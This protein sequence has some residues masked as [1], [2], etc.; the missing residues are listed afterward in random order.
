MIRT[1]PN[2]GEK[3]TSARTHDK[4]EFLAADATSGDGKAVAGARTNISEDERVA[5]AK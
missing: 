5:I 1:I 4:I 3:Q 2:G